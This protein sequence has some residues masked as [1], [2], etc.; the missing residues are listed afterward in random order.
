MGCHMCVWGC[1][2]LR[3]VYIPQLL[4]DLCMHMQSETS[5]S[6]AG[7]GTHLLTGSQVLL[8]GSAPTK[9]AVTHGLHHE[10]DEEE[11]PDLYHI[12]DEP[13]QHDVGCLPS[14]QTRCT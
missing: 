10:R 12:D 9:I 2:C 3:A 14:L 13:A 11:R 1:K 6:T 7:Q 5:K 4:R 8:H